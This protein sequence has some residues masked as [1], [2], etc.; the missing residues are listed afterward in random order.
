LA[1][2]PFAGICISARLSIPNLWYINYPKLGIFGKLFRLH[3]CSVKHI[4]TMNTTENNT[5]TVF[6]LMSVSEKLNERCCCCLLFHP[7]LRMRMCM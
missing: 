4:N 3:L 5:K 1:D 6:H 2:L 7:S